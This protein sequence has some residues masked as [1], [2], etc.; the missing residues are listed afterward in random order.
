MKTPCIRAQATKIIQN[1]ISTWEPANILIGT[2]NQDN[3]KLI[4]DFKLPSCWEVS[5]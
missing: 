4:K 2:G 5:S 1:I 3:P